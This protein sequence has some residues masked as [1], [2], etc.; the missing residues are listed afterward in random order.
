MCI[1]LCAI[2][3]QLRIIYNDNTICAVS[4]QLVCKI[5]YAGSDQN[6]RNGLVI[7]ILCQ[8]I[9]FAQKLQ[10]NGADLVINLLSKDKYSFVIL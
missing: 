9:G 1:G 2:I 8:I 3:L 7:Q 4:C 5:L 6:C 10:S